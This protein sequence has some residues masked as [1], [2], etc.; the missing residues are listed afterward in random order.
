M[1]EKAWIGLQILCVVLHSYSYYSRSFL[2]VSAALS[3]TWYHVAG[4][5][6]GWARPTTSQPPSSLE[7][8]KAKPV[9]VYL[10]PQFQL[11]KSLMRMH[12]GLTFA[13]VCA[14]LSSYELMMIN[15]SWFM[16]E[17]LNWWFPSVLNP[18][19]M[20]EGVRDSCHCHVYSSCK[21]FGEKYIQCCVSCWLISAICHNAHNMLK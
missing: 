18:Q 16:N 6:H 10:G 20:F 15:D 19:N 8:G 12:K 3:Q 4:W 5:Q 2:N 7:E 1:Y 14:S 21:L 9:F 13:C 17:E 11:L